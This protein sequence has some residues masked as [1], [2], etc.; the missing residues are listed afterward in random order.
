[1][2]KF[3]IITGMNGAGKTVALKTMEDMGYFCVDNL[4]V[5]LIPQFA[6]LSFRDD[7]ETNVA[8]G[9]DTRSGKGFTELKEALDRIREKGIKYE[10]LF[11]DASDEVLIKRYKESR[12]HHPLAPKGRIE[13]GI[14]KE[15]VAVSW[16]R[17][18]ADYL[19]DTSKLIARELKIQLENILGND[20][21]NY[22]NMVINIVSFGFK[23]GI[24]QDADL[25]FDV[26]FLP[27]PYYEDHLKS[28]T[29]LSKE[30]RDYVNKDGSAAEFLSRFED[31]I[32]FLLPQ[33]VKEGKNQL[34]IA[35]GCTGGKHRSVSV[36]ESVYEKLSMNSDYIVSILH[37][38]LA[39]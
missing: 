16:L 33:Y 13:E 7:S 36:A 31:M 29:G 24:P 6:E 12:R 23:H 38:D 34:V 3:L 35:F 17:S 2:M 5:F 4:P 18:E 20:D 8:L 32:G 37:R 19:I 22:K 10:V 27:N 1:M 21:E 14:E 26:R 39:K 15:R 28:L 25:V 11:L 9:I 30:V